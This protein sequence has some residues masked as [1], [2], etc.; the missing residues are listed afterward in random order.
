MPRQPAASTRRRT[1]LLL[2]GGAVAGPLFMVVS[3]AQAFTR[4]GFDLRRQAISMLSL[5]EGGWLQIANFLIT[6]V[7]ALALALGVHQVLRRGRAGAWGS[8]LLGAYGA[9]LIAAGLFHPDPGYGF[10]PGA[11]AGAPATMSAH[12]M[13][14]NLAFFVAFIGLIAASLV[15]A[16][17]EAGLGRRRWA[18]YCLATGLSA[19]VFIALAATGLVASGVALAVLGLVTSGWVAAVSIHLLREQQ[20]R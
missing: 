14:H 12:A 17:R 10:P 4:P 6:G 8:L 3:L 16:R 5:G 18:V 13:V 7:L 1:R 15:F 9:G 2:A 19:P 11:P 20:S